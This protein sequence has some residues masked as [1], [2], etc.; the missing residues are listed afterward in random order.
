LGAATAQRAH[1]HAAIP[2]HEQQTPSQ[3]VRATNV[4]SFPLNKMLKLVITVVQQIMTESNGAVSEEAKLLAIT[5][6]VFNL[7]EQ[8]GH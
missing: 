8:I 2:Q 7:M 3:S 6:I 4:N 5:K 1:V